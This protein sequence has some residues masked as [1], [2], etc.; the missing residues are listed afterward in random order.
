MIKC[1]ITGSQRVDFKMR[2]ETLYKT[3]FGRYL[4]GDSV[5]LIDEQLIKS[6]RGKVDLIITS[7]PF[8]LNQKK[9]YGNLKGEKYKEWFVNLAPLFSELLA[10]DGS[11]VIE[12]GNAWEPGMPV[13]STLHLE[14][15]LGFLNHP[16]AG[17]KLCQELVCY[18]PS[19]LPSPAQWVTIE[20]SR[21]IDSYTHVWWMSKSGSPKADN[22]KVLR[23][24]SKSMKELLKRQRYNSGRR[25]SDHSISKDSFLKSH[26][27]S[28]MPNLIELNQMEGNKDWRLPESVL[29]FSNT[30]SNDSFMR[31]CRENK[32]TPH[33]ARMNPA[34]ISFFLEFLTD[35]G[36]LILDPFAG[37]NTTGFVAE[38]LGRKWLS[39]EALE[40]YGRQAIL[41]FEA[42][43]IK[44]KVNN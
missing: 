14:S 38:L 23:P 7:P 33:P 26:P 8:P 2:E 28:I 35:P 12:I 10:P 11:I 5:S 20:R 42:E 44:L 43:K 13:Q 22:S 27:G 17:L 37:T 1:L 34:L 19:R 25:P 30:S 29:R 4:I 16:D 39:I 41:R 15:L 32:I 18:N 6:R 40:E 21:L 3:K 24:Y 36:N 9:R 31:I